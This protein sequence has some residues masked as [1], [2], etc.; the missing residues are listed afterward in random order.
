MRLTTVVLAAIALASCSGP[1]AADTASLVAKVTWGLAD[2]ERMMIFGAGTGTVERVDTSTFRIDMGPGA[3]TYAFTELAPCRV[4]TAIALGR[5]PT[6]EG[7]Y[8]FTK[9]TGIAV[10][11]DTKANEDIGKQVDLNVVQ[12]TLDGTDFAQGQANPFGTPGMFYFFTSLSTEEVQ[13]A[14][15]E[16]QRIC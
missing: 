10:K 9:V 16:L 14:A 8:D 7:E 15:D 3:M 11:A 12:V 13:A 5:N 4:K 6:V 2:G 1:P